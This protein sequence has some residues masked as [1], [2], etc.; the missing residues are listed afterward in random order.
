MEKSPL[1][2]SGKNSNN[3]SYNDL[4]K[5]LYN[6]WNKVIKAVP[7]NE[8]MM[9]AQIYGLAEEMACVFPANE[10]EDYRLWN[11]ARIIWQ[12]SKIFNEQTNGKKN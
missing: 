4:R 12:A 1:R 2:K 8:T 11:F 3:I 7:V 9:R 5:E 6:W 10:E